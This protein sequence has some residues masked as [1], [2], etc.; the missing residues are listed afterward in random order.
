MHGAPIHIGDPELIGIH[1]LSRPDYGDAVEIRKGE[2]PVFWACGVTPQSVAME[3][4][5]SLC[6]TH[7][8]GYML[9]TDL[10]NATFP[11]CKKYDETARTLANR[12][13]STVNY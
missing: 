10:K 4:K 5:P 3:A 9:I 8:P 11:S 7:S 6:I 12:D 2:L 1:D 13:E